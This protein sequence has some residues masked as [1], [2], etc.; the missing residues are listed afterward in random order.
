MPFIRNLWVATLTSNSEDAGTESETVFI[1]NKGGLDVVHRDM[2]LFRE[3]AEGGGSFTFF[4]VSESQIIPEDYYLRVGIRGSDAWRPELI[5]AW[6]QRFTSGNIVPLGYNEQIA[7]ILSTDSS[8]GRISLPLP[9]V[10]LGA[11]RTEISRVLL[12]TVTHFSDF[13]TDSPVNVRITRGDEVVVDDT[14]VDTPQSD[15]ESGQANL[16]FLPALTPFTRSQLTDSSI[17]LSIKGD[18]AWRPITVVMFGLDEPS[19]NP[20][21]IV[22]LVHVHPWPFGVL[23]TDPDEG[24]PSMTLP[25]A[26]VDP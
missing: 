15:F 9:R 21:Q 19:G 22:P 18:D 26:P 20:G 8:E 23:S 3:V 1:M 13:A 12:M 11:I 6:C 17:E 4:D 5:A 24:V 16:Y 14:I 7:T 2:G 10:V 25:L